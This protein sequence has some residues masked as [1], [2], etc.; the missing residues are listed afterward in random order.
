MVNRIIRFFKRNCLASQIHRIENLITEKK[1]AEASVAAFLALDKFP[2]QPELLALKQ[3][4]ET[5]GFASYIY[6]QEF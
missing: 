6:N 1:Y 5:Q 3:Q 4:A 2:E